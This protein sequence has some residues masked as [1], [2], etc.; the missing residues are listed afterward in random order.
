MRLR[1][2]LLR[3]VR[4]A[5]RRMRQRPGFTALAALTLG[6]GI[7]V[8][9]A[10]MATAYGVLLR[11]LPYRSPDR[12]AVVNLLFPDGGDLGFSPSD[13]PEWLRRLNG[14]EAAAAYYTREVTIR[15]GSRTTVVRAAFATD[16]FFDVFG[17]APETGQARLGPE[18]PALAIARNRVADVLGADAAHAVDTPVVL[19]GSSRTVTAVLPSEFAFPSGQVGVW[20]P[21]RVGTIEAGYSKIAVRLRPGVTIAQFRDDVHRVRRELDPASRESVSV[22]SLGE[23]IAG[24]TR[25]LLI[26]VVIGSVLVL[27][28]ACA[29]VATLFIGRDIG[30]RREFA[31]RMALGAGRRDLVRS[32]LTEAF[33][34]A[35]VASGVGLLLGSAALKW[36][37]GAAAA[38]FPRLLYL[39]ADA[40]VAAATVCLTGAVA[41]LSGIVPAWQA[42]RDDV[43]AFL[44]PT[45]SSHPGAWTARRLLVIAQI[46]CCCM[47]L[48]GAGLLIRTITVLLQEDAGFDRHGALAAKV[49]LSDVVLA[50][51]ER[52]AFV[53]TL[54][55]RTRALPGVRH[56]GFGSS[57]PP[58]TPVVEMSVAVESNGV[59]QSRLVKVGSATPGFLPAL[60]ARF[61]AGRD[62]EDTD[63]QSAVVVLSESLARFYFVNRD[64]VGQ[65]FV[66]LPSM[67]GLGAAPRV[68]GVV[69]DM[70]YDG[71]DAP[72]GGAL[73]LPWSSRPFGTGY[74]IVRTTSDPRHA[75]GDIRRAVAVLDP[76]VP[77]PEALPLDDI[78]A[79]SIAGRRLRAVPAAAFALLAL[80]VAAVGI[81]ATLSTLVAEKRRDLAIRSALGASRERL[82]WTI[83]RQGIALTTVGLVAGIGS[84]AVAAR[85]LASLLY[86]VRPYDAVTFAGTTALILVTATLMT[87]VAAFR[88][89]RIDPVAALRQD[90]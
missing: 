39:R 40:A 43:S 83:A 72:A 56:A 42:G 67:F 68:I 18:A 23:S 60:G 61:L 6:L 48:I 65:T 25:R 12:I 14:T 55:E 36:F 10:A 84:G 66:Q 27:I 80:A 78:A 30:R 52:T 44:K 63:A 3:D 19:G 45:S 29:N 11:P 16:E 21:W 28:V 69:A 32:V 26:A 71:L 50:G 73:Y 46:A 81:M 86:G 85:A 64:P 5:V 87:S 76:T 41:V 58:R 77:V 20:L 47:L 15:A 75:L 88:T 4:D 89:L 35:L 37:A 62:F 79:Q 7:A 53:R 2:I 74:L 9:S 57:L 49:V 13:V 34:F 38:E 70:K 59:R 1:E 8:N 33:V 90:S 51:P 24:G 82:A 17:V 31:T 54:L 22:T